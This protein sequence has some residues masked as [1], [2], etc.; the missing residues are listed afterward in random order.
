MAKSAAD[1]RSGFCVTFVVLRA[2]RTLVDRELCRAFGLPGGSRF[3][4]IPL[5][6]GD[7]VNGEAGLISVCGNVAKNGIKQRRL[8]SISYFR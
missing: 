1:A 5:V 3:L 7:G 6:M 4:V 2:R 8:L